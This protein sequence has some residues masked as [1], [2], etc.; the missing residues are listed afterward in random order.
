MKRARSSEIFLGGRARARRRLAPLLAAAAFAYLV[1]V[2][3]KLSGLGSWED[4][5][6]I[7]RPETAASRGELLQRDALER[8]PRGRRAAGGGATVTGYGRITGEI[9][10][11]HEALGGG[12]RRRWG[13]RGNFSELERMAAQAWALGAKAWEEASAFSGDVDAI[14]S[15]DGAAVKCPTSL[16][17][18]GGGEGE[19]AAF[20]PCGLAVGSAVTVVATAREAVAEYVEALERSGSGNG[21]VMVAQFAVELRGLRA[22]EGEDPPRIL[23]LNPRLRGDWSRRPVLEMNTCFRMQWGKAQRCD[24]TPSK[25]DDHVDGF[26]RCEKWERRDM[27]DSKETKT[28]SWFNRFIG[29]AK[30]P[31]MT[32]PYPFLEGKM[33]VLTIQAGVEGYHIN[34]GGRHVASFPHRMGF[35]LED[36]TGLAVTGGIDVHSV[37]ATSLP[38]THPSFSLQNVLE[39]S[40][41][42]KARPVPEE[43]IQLFI[44]ILSATN[45]FAERMAIRKTWMQFPAIQLG[46][47]V[48]RFFVALSHRKEINA[49]LKKEAEYFG[50]VVIL[51]FIDRYEL[52][53][54][55]TV[56]ICQYGVQNVTAEYIM[57]CDDDTFVRLDVVLQQVSTFNRTLPLYLGNLNLLH[58]PLRSGKWAV[59]FEE[60]PELVYPPYANGPGYVISIGIARNIVSR[61]ANQSLWLFK[62]EDVSMGMWVEDYNTTTIT[63]PVQYIHSWK[64]CQY[65]CVDNYFTA[66]YQSPR[67]MLCL[68][69]KLSLGRAQCCN[70]R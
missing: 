45:H 21:T 42:W 69:D 28:S 65:G 12:S 51:P 36:A 38:K 20:L 5:A 46:N 43:P 26:P 24:G 2:S 13:L 33:F 16:E 11:R 18:G 63:A 19:T 61:H 47:V 14:V 54:L 49:A 22:S 8:A 35:T 48:A 1:F 10:R 23:H 50:D 66:H 15:G 53:V 9:L 56:A 44:G 31:E 40:D 60:W 55:K 58:R 7:P 34:V 6:A 64:F 29:R 27:A 68:W 62:M 39:M 3:V 67:Q 4:A 59:T 52:V 41:K 37:Y 70:Y 17:L 57:K 32:W 25:D 30:K